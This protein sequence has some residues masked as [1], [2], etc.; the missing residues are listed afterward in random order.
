MTTSV[1]FS[2]SEYGR[3]LAAMRAKMRERGAELVLVDEA[4]HLAY[5]TGFDRS[6][7]RYQACVVPLEGDPVTFLRSLDEPGFLERSWL[8]GYVTIADWED[9]VV[10]ISR[11]LERRGWAD[12]R[13]GLEL[14]SN[15]LTVRRWQTLTAALPAASF[16]DF[17]EVLRELRLRKSPEEIAL[18]RRAASI[19]D[20]AMAAAVAAAGEG[21]NEREAAA[22][23]SRAF[24]ELGADTARAGVITSGRRAGSLH[25]G[26]G[27]HRLERG[28]LL[29]MELVPQVH[30]YSARIM[31]PTAIG[32]PSAT[33]V[34][35]AR[36]LVELQDRQLAAMKPGAVASDV[37]RIVR[38]GVLAVKLRDRYENATGYTLG[39]YAPWSPRTSDFTR[40]FVPTATWALE[41]GMVFHMYVAA[42]GLAF[43]ETVLVTDAGAERLTGTERVLFVR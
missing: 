18:L 4:E 19:A 24:L 40:L 2:R 42:L 37:D 6:A 29:H 21:R 43:S 41:P 28:D 34:D 39:Y 14:D 25:G 26:L 27:T 12:R 35:A 5:L 20:R 11:E 38:E 17:G 36:V 31:R 10:V 32:T 13:I 33:H 22:A 30:G 1:V 7:T 9:P 15:Y 3:R 16:V 23:A 8:T